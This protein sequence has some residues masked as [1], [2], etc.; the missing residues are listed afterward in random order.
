MKKLFGWNAPTRIMQQI[1]WSTPH[2]LKHWTKLATRTDY[3]NRRTE[4]VRLTKLPDY[5][6]TSTELLGPKLEIVD[7]KSFLYTHGEIFEREIYR[8]KTVKKA[9]LIIDGGANIGLSVIY[10]KKMF[11]ESRIVA[12]EPDPRI[13]SVLKRNCESFAF[14][15]VDLIPKGLWTTETTLQFKQEGAEAGRITQ[16]GNPAKLI[17]VPT[18]RLRD[19]LDQEIDMLKFNIEGAETEVLL[20]CA[21]KLQ[22][23]ERLFVEYHSLADEPQT[24]HK[25]TGLLTESGFRLHVHSVGI[26]DHP[27]IW[28]SVNYGMDMQLNI[29]AVRA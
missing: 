14:D 25:L 22:N 3:R 7:A 9:P 20:D 2:R 24:L 10:F 16:Q 13:F 21:D 4:V 1:R 26:S 15:K 19:Y 17:D 29:Y 18:V 27:F 28:R 11:P 8:F 6:P 23:V 5:T 12:F